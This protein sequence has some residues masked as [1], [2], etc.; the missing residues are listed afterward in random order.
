MNETLGVVFLVVT[1][2]FIVV[3]FWL[4][5]SV[6]RLQKDL[7]LFENVL[8]DKINATEGRRQDDR[9]VTMLLL[10][11]FNLELKTIPKEVTL[12]FID[13]PQKPTESK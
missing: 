5:L 4:S 11:Y 13:P 9:K 2:V 1:T 6:Y 7:E 12:E 8:S 10:R 3:L